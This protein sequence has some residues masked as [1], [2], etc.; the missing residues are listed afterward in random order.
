M[1][2][3]EPTRVVCLNCFDTGECLA[4][5]DGIRNDTGEPC[6]EC[7]GTGRCLKCERENEDAN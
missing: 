1:D 7:G 2:N 3:E 6:E 4:C 5:T